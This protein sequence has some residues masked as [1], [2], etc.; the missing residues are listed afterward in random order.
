MPPREDPRLAEARALPIGEVAERL[1]IAGLKPPQ[2]I[3][4]VGPCPVCGGRDRFGINT[5]RN[6]YN[7]RHCGGGD[8]IALV[9][10]VKGCDFRA[11]LDWLMGTR[12]LE[13]DPAELARR[14]AARE[15]EAR[16]RIRQAEAARRNAIAQARAIWHDSRP[17]EDSPVR[18]YLAR[19]GLTRARLPELPACLRFHPDLPY[20]VP[21]GGNR[22]RWREIHRGPAMVALVQAPGGRGSGIHRTWLDLDQ[23]KG[24]AVIA[25]E[26]ESLAAKKTLGSVKGGAIRLARSSGTRAMVMGEGIETT[27]SAL[28]AR[29]L[30][31]A[32]FW[33]GISLGNMAGRRITRGKGMRFA[34]VPDLDD[35]QAWLPPAGVEHLVFIQDG[36]SEPRSTRAQLLSGLRRARARVPSVTRISI[37]HAGEGRDLNDVLMGEGEE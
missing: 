33:A 2:A 7:C 17:A 1:G 12:E 16:Q 19:R 26:G 28:A 37:V 10:L 6:V 15:K 30:P 18:D 34:G 21:A 11:A 22:G 27:F 14:K 32:A 31:G 36:D 25:H 24:K 5:A 23:P 29:A 4:R 13:T 9:G 3:E 8:A 35:L 20:M